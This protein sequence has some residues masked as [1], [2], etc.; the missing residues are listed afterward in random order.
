M[1]QKIAEKNAHLSIGI[2]ECLLHL[3]VAVWPGGC[4]SL[5]ILIGKDKRSHPD[6]WTN[7]V[8]TSRTMYIYILVY[9]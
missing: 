1:T 8:Y 7:H 2:H 4:S 3:T 9:V 6:T 5:G